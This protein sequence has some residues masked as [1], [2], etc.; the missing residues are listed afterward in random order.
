MSMLITQVIKIMRSIFMD[1]Y[2]ILWFIYLLLISSLIFL[3]ISKYILLLLFKSVFNLF[4]SVVGSVL[5]VWLICRFINWCS[6]LFLILY[7]TSHHTFQI[8]KSCFR[9]RNCIKNPSFA[10]IMR[11]MKIQIK[12]KQTFKMTS[13]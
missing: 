13:S 6:F 8:S 11:K 7:N 10:Q 4:S 12:L 3:Y 5:N 2:K 1:V 9:F